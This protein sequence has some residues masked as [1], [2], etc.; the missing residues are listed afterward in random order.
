MDVSTPFIN[1]DD[2]ADIKKI[3]DA[4]Q[5]CVNY[6]TR[7]KG[8]AGEFDVLLSLFPIECEGESGIIGWNVEI[9]ERKKIEEELKT[10]QYL[11]S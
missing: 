9:T 3:F 4:G 11:Q 6:E 8:E 7:L 10:S 1:K 2:L 5:T